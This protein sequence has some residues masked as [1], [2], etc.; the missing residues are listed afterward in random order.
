MFIVENGLGSADILQNETVNDE[1]RISY[2]REHVKAIY[3]A[4]DI[5]GVDVMGYTPWSFLDIVSAS[6]GERRKRYG[7]VYVDYDDEGIGTGNRYL[8]SSYYW[9]K[10][11]IASNGEDLD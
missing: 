2:Y 8:K 1:Y 3:D 11:L 10:K 4:I 6:T 9:Y 5:D 7:F